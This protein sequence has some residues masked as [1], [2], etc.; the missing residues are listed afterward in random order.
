[1]SCNLIEASSILALGSNQRKYQMD[2]L[3]SL[4]S[5]LV[6]L[7]IVFYGLSKA[8]KKAEKYDAFILNKLKM[9]WLSDLM[10]WLSPFLFLYTVIKLVQKIVH[11]IDPSITFD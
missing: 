1:M 11:F 6:A 7:A 9:P 4:F 3:I 5:G 2:F 10:W 8:L